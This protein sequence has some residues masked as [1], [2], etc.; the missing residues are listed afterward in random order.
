MSVNPE[1]HQR[2]EDEAAFRA[3]LAR[4]G[5]ARRSVWD[6]VHVM[7]RASRWL[8]DMG[9]PAAG[10][11]PL[12][13]ADLQAGLPGAGPVLGFLRR[14]GAVP[15]AGSAAGAAPAE[16]LLEQFRSWL[17]QSGACRLRRWCVTAS[18]L[19][20]SWRTWASRWMRPCGS[21]MPGKSPRSCSAT[22]GA[23]TPSRRRP[24]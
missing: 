24:P 4:S 22:A 15:A 13:A 2:I 8:E 23:V 3:D 5:Y 20:S 17:S 1:R 14:I 7:A 18:R 9:L 12:V 16:A 11:T 6:L 21:W 19:A 10:L